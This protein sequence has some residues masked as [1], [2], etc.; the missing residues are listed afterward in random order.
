MALFL[1]VLA[2]PAVAK[3]VYVEIPEPAGTAVTVN[4]SPIEHFGAVSRS[5][6]RQVVVYL[7]RLLSTP[8]QLRN[9]LVDLAELAPALAELGTVEVVSAGEETVTAIAGTAD[10]AQLADALEFL[11]IRT[12]AD[13]GQAQIRQEFIEEAGLAEMVETEHFAISATAGRRLAEIG[14]LV[15][16]AIADEVRLLSD[17][18][19][20]LVDWAVENATGVP[21]ILILVGGGFDADIVAFYENL[22][23]PFEL[24][25]LARGSGAQAPQPPVEELTQTLSALGWTV[26]AF[27]P[28]GERDILEDAQAEE[29]K[30]RVETVFEGGRRVDRTIFTPQFDPIKS[31]KKRLGDKGAV[32][33]TAALADPKS[34]LEALVG[35]T[36]GTV[37]EDRPGFRQALDRLAARQQVLV[38]LP[39]GLEGPALL[40][41]RGGSDH[42]RRWISA[43]PPPLVALVRARQI[44]DGDLGDGGLVV[45]AAAEESERA[46]DLILQIAVSTEE[47]S[48]EPRV[49]ER[50]NATAVIVEDDDELES[51]RKSVVIPG[52]LSGA[53]EMEVPSLRSSDVPVIVVVEDPES[54][55]WGGAFAALITGGGAEDGGYGG[56]LPAPRAIHLLAP[57]EPLAVGKT[58]IDT[59]LSER[60]AKVEFYLDGSLEMVKETA[61]FS[62]T[63]TLGKY[64]ER[65]RVEAVAY[66]ASGVEI[67]RDRLILNAGTGTFRVR[68]VSPEDPGQPGSPLSGMVDVRAAIELPRGA[69]MERVQFFWNE[70][71]FATRFAPPYRQRFTIPGDG[72]SGFFRVVA[73]L[74]DG[75]QTEDVLFVNSPAGSERI[76]VELVELYT[77]VTDRRGRPVTRLPAEAFKVYED[78]VEQEVAT[79]SEAGDLP[80]TVGLA[81][82]SSA[83]MFVKLPDV[84][85]AATG[86]IQ[87]LNSPADR[88]F[89]VGFGGG[90]Q[91]V[92][93]TSRDLNEV[94]RALGRLQPDGKTE[95]WKGIVY[96]LVQLQGVPGKKALVVYSDGA[97]EDPEF[98]YKTCL[99]FAR[100]VG[101][102]VF[103]IVSNDEIFRTQGR[104]LTNRGFMNRLEGLVRSVGGRVYLTRVGEDLES[105]YTEINQELRSQ[106]L[107]G[108]YVRDT[109]DDRWRDIRVNVKGG[110]LEA[111]TI[112]GYYR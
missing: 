16:Q 54:G 55:R 52:S 7:D 3:E 44:L 46:T 58:R 62:I 33:P 4:G 27:R 15:R 70:S 78:G 68:I 98:S 95:I 76:R 107:L 73:K 17:H 42:V 77:V 39:D 71:L 10:S 31:L 104:G 87:G 92:H 94:Q 18:R 43:G 96:S 53:F 34:A 111:R 109:E 82:D 40:E 103:V 106:Y 45:E 97:D 12:S 5:E 56:F 83:S 60:V 22:L 75:S 50:L 37:V 29:E 48:G 6:S 24:S 8:L 9:A 84:Q 65:R 28:E 101:V 47:E 80:L 25:D 105:I 93:D 38:Q 11:R 100:R 108:Y 32:L 36:G 23:K 85:R 2:L 110:R 21:Q 69:E 1:P 63:V 72:E 41:A 14:E 13:G 112:S 79:F 49:L 91:L 102:P 61:P 88:A 90:P 35:L 81:V 64:P 66:E 89:V 20:G 74:G 99:R 19:S 86:F 51:T 57:R 59:V 67:G 26:V 30:A